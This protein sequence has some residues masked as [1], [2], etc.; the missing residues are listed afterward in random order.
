[1]RIPIAGVVATRLVAGS[2]NIKF[3]FWCADTRGS[4]GERRETAGRASR[5][6]EVDLVWEG[7]V[8]GK[9][10]LLRWNIQSRFLEAFTG[11]RNAKGGKRGILTWRKG[12][13]E[14]AVRGEV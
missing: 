8:E 13:T 1:M 2:E 14:R 7:I 3:D 11:G 12:R 6:Q 4:A 5:A 10:A 9:R